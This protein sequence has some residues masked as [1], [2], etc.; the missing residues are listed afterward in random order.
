MAHTPAEPWNP[1]R[2]AWLSQTEE[3][4]RPATER[5]SALIE[6]RRFGSVA[7]SV[8]FGNRAHTLQRVETLAPGSGGVRLAI[9]ALKAIADRFGGVLC[10]NSHAYPTPECPEP[11]Q[12]RL[13][14]FYRSCGFSLGPPPYFWIHYPPKPEH[15]PPTT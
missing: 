13:N 9:I 6:W 15:L 4:I 12:D 1:A 2:E 3:C 14:A 7:L 5:S 10:G 8:D 11:D